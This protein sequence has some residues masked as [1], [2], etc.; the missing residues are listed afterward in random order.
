MSNIEPVRWGRD[1][2]STLVY[3]ETRAVDFQGVLHANHLRTNSDKRPFGNGAGWNDKYS[4]RL[5]NGEIVAGHDD[6]DV[7][8][9]LEAAGLLTIVSLVN[10]TIKM[11]P[12]GIRLAHQVRYHL[13]QG[14]AYA[15]FVVKG[16]QRGKNAS[17]TNAVS[18]GE[19]RGHQ[20]A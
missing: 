3:A 15:S 20:G 5:A 18:R 4:T 1:H 19:H 16:K 10:R 6:I 8:E 13:I 2:F 9:D 17:S 11:K 12:K 14:G 7:L